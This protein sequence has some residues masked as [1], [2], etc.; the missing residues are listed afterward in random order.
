MDTD[1]PKCQAIFKKLKISPYDF[2]NQIA[3]LLEYPR[4]HLFQLLGQEIENSN[5]EFEIDQY[6]LFKEPKV[7]QGD[8]AKAFYDE[9]IAELVE[10]LK[11]CV[12]KD[13]KITDNELKSLKEKQKTAF[14]KGMGYKQ[15]ENAIDEVY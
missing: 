8:K 3:N 11:N 13:K 5:S 12:P 1:N 7:L 9:L 4:E 6:E 10:V 15:F 2:Q 14:T